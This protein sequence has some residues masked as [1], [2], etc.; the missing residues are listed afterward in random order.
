MCLVLG[1]ERNHY[2]HKSCYQMPDRLLQPHEND[3]AFQVLSVCL[4]HSH[5]S[6]QMLLTFLQS[7]SYLSIS[8]FVISASHQ[9]KHRQYLPHTWHGEYTGTC[10][11]CIYS[12]NTREVQDN[13]SP[14]FLA[15][16]RA[17]IFIFLL[18]FTST[19]LFTFP[20]GCRMLFLE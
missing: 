3:V 6:I 4:S 18:T 9:K 8:F 11:K 1:Q 17:F 19:Y 7:S 5:L 10:N 15:D 16:I 14:P 13:I 2:C 20:E 12:K